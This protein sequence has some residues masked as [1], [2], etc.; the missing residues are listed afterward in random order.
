[1][2]KYRVFFKNN[3]Q[4]YFTADAVNGFKPSTDSYV[5]KLGQEVV[6]VVPKANVQS[7]EKVDNGG[8][9]TFEPFRHSRI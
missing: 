9:D 5:F 7:V 1:M 2:N 8:E 6:G 3:D 4:K